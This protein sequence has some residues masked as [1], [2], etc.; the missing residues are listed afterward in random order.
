MQEY[1]CFFWDFDGTLYDT[2]EGIVRAV[3]KGMD[4][5]GLDHSGIDILSLAKTTLRQA[6]ETLAGHDRADELLSHYFMHAQDEGPETMKPFPGCEEALRSVVEAGGVNYL[7]T[8]RNNTALEALKNDGLIDLFRDFITYEAGFP[9]KPA[10]DALNWLI[11]LHRLE[12][13]ECV[14]I[15]D[16]VIDAQAG[17]NAGIASALFDPDGYFSES[18]ADYRFM[19]LEDIPRKLMEEQAG[20]KDSQDE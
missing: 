20:P 19:K 18:D 16:R 10:P 2:Y 15:G 11:D 17:R 6:C 13:R 7:Y 12:R 4:E 14:M 5:M 1:R 9:D 8:H 3:K